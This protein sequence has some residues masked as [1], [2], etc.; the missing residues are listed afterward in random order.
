MAPYPASPGAHASISAADSAVIA[1][2]LVYG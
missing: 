2:A 1:G